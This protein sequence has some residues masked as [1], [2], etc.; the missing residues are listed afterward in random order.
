MFAKIGYV[1]NTFIEQSNGILF[2][3]S[4]CEIFKIHRHIG[5]QNWHF[6]YQVL[7]VLCYFSSAAIFDQTL[8]KRVLFLGSVMHDEGPKNKQTTRKSGTVGCLDH[9]IPFTKKADNDCKISICK[10]KITAF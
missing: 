5:D 8:A 9:K 10:L 2:S 1:F 4:K 7:F 3:E 6:Y